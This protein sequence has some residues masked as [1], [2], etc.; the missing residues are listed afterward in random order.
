MAGG[1]YLVCDGDARRG[2]EGFDYSHLAR[3]SI[4]KN[5]SLQCN[6]EA[7]TDNFSGNATK[8]V[9]NL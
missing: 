4:K 9:S 2:V 3:Q 7:V 8:T 1:W 5:L 6:V